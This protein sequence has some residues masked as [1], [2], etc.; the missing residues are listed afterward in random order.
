MTPAIIVSH[1][2]NDTCATRAKVCSVLAKVIKST[3]V[4]QQ[5][6]T[7]RRTKK[8]CYPLHKWN[9]PLFHM[10]LGHTNPRRREKKGGER[11]GTLLCTLQ[12]MQKRH[13]S[14][15]TQGCKW[16]NQSS[17][18]RKRTTVDL[19]LTKEQ[20]QQRKLISESCCVDR[21]NQGIV[22][23]ISETRKNNASMRTTTMKTGLRKLLR[24]SEQS[25]H[26][27]QNL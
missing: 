15:I 8:T 25:R 20:Q 23:R 27:L 1:Q 10:I 14:I 21:S 5:K 24:S 4:P 6:G 9:H 11:N 26:H 16:L 17:S 3:A 12:R 13:K 18:W 2:W 22:S 7:K 19:T